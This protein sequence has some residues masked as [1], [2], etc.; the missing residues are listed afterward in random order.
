MPDE[1]YYK[2]GQDDNRLNEDAAPAG[3]GDDYDAQE[4]IQEDTELD[5]LL[6]FLVKTITSAP[7]VPLS[8]GKRMVSMQM[9]LDIV[10]DIRNCLPDEVRYSAEIL[11]RRDRI[12]RDAQSTADSKTQAAEARANAALDDANRRAQEIVNSAE[13]RAADILEEAENRARAMIEQ[14]EITRLAHEE[15][16]RVC[17]EARAEASDIKLEASSYAETLLQGLASDVQ[18]TLDA[19]HDSLTRL[20][21]GR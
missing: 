11:K 1:R 15:A 4:E 16:D 6:D 19:V 9:C 17:E 3:Y 21:G 20:A 10:E 18:S 12:I 8:S 14:S 13:D 2:D 7:A 5:R